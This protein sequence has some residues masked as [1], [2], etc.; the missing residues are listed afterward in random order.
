MS[1]VRTDEHDVMRIG[2]TRVMLDSVVAGYKEGLSPE[3]IRRQYPSLALEQVYGAITYYLAH[4]EEVEAYL[5]RQDELW[6]RL[7]SE[8]DAHPSAVV[9]RLRALHDQQPADLP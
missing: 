7:R 5:R 8:A 1:Y 6:A 3:S 2:D 9:T 4:Q